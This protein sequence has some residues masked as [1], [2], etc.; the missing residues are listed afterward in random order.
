MTEEQSD[1][2]RPLNGATY[3]VVGSQL[4]A[5][6][7]ADV[8]MD[9]LGDTNR[10]LNENMRAIQRLIPYLSGMYYT[11]RQRR[12][13]EKEL[14]RLQKERADLGVNVYNALVMMPDLLYP[15]VVAHT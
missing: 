11:D 15:V 3:E 12:Y 7:I 10:Q 8:I 13:A 5:G 4:N 2:D 1:E 14:F 6:Y 9:T